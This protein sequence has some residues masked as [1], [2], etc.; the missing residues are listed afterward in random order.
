MKVACDLR[1]LPKGLPGQA[2]LD[3]QLV[4]STGGQAIARVHQVLVVDDEP[5]TRSMCRLALQAEGIPCDEA[6][7]GTLA[8]Q[9]IHAKRYDL[10]LSDIDMPEM[11]GPEVLRQLR[12]VPPCPHL[13]IIMISGRASSDE[14]AQ[15]LLAGADDYLT[16]PLSMVQ[17]LSRVKAAL[18]LKDAQDRADLL[19]RNLLTVNHQL[20]QNLTARESDLI[21]ARNALVLA[22]AELVAYRDTETGAHLMRL[23]RYSRGLA[24]EATNLRCFAGQI[25]DHFIQMLECCAPLHDIGKVGL[26]D[27]ILLKPGKLDADERVLMQT[28]TTIGADTLH[29]VAE[30]HGFAAGFFRMAID[31]ARH[32][33]E[34]YDGRGYPDRLEGEDIPLAARIVAVA[35]VYD[36][37]RSRRAYKPALSHAA[38]VQLMIEASP[39]QFDPHLFQAF[40][41]CAPRIERISRELLD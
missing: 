39:G 28:H 38:A 30:R 21:H 15:M 31:I 32:H 12:E 36:A 11:T 25:D 13:K 17:L 23:Q 1:D 27:Y 4:L 5:D 33:H 24:E 19:N 18:R 6:A 14:M 20:E 35:D 22:L 41:R 26:P 37:L 7:N 8:L 10:V 2:A 40:H 3:E 9:A 29:K 34:R 16:K